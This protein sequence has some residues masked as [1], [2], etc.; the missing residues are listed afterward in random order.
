[1]EEESSDAQ[2]G[3]VVKV[4]PDALYVQTGKNLLKLNEVQIQGKKR[5]PVK[6][7]LLG[8]KVEIGTLLGQDNENN[9]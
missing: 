8:H 7:F 5:M 6:A 4:T 9:R 2:P 3:T 1:M